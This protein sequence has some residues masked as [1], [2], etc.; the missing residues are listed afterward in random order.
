MLKI[1][2]AANNNF[3]S[4]IQLARFMQAMDGKPYQIKIAAYINSSPK[5]ISIDWTLDS[6]LNFYKPEIISLEND[7]FRIYHDQIKYYAPDL[8]ISDLEY[9][10]SYIANVLNVTLWQC[11]S[12]IINFAL[13]E[14]Y[15]LGL[16]KKYS[17]VFNRNPQHVQ[18][19]VNIIDNSNCNF[20]YS[21]LGDMEKA[22]A[23]KSNFEWIRPYHNIGKSYIPCK[24][25]LMTALLQNNI[26]IMSLLKKHTD[27]V[28]F[29]DFYQNSNFEL[30]F[31]DINNTDEYTCNMYNSN[32]FI[33]EGQTN[34]LADAFYNGKYSIIIPNFEDSE[35]L[36]NSVLT[37][38]FQIGK[39][40]YNDLV[41]VEEFYEKK[42]NIQKN[43][44]IKFL[45]ERIEEI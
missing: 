9:F 37:D 41:K 17:Y 32:L 40:I 20:V 24:H 5:N 21:H 7:N 22:P 15:D 31:K 30:I 16:F 42:I 3:S 28:V 38:H 19:L 29:S 33:C 23:L 36:I 8:I 35:C 12:S 39:T 27:C 4:K 45:S 2:Y 25:N 13:E 43:S 34:F 26:K 18:R 11:S 1:L 10:T 44:H 14:K 6:L